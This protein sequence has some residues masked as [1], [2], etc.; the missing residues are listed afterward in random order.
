M[1]RVST[2]RPT[3]KAAAAAESEGDEGDEWADRRAPLDVMIGSRP[4]GS[5]AIGRR[6]SVPL[7]ALYPFRPAAAPGAP[8]PPKPQYPDFDEDESDE[9][10]FELP[11]PVPVEFM[12]VRV[13]GVA[14]GRLPCGDSW[15]WGRLRLLDQNPIVSTAG[16]VLG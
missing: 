12:V 6:P 9:E 2:R 14:Q 13:C 3:G 11:L 10:D 4:K 5:R 15:V 16:M 1:G 8:A 7:G